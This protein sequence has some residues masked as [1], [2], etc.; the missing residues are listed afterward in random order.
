VT[1]AGGGG[2]GL[3]RALVRFAGLLLAALPLGAGFVLIL[4]DR[5][6]RGLQDLLAH[7]VVVDAPRRTR[8]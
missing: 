6:R 2:F 4:F 8:G 1:S 5:R 7:T 3:K